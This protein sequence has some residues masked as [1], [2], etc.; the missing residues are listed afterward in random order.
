M[1]QSLALGQ[2]ITQIYTVTIADG[3]GG[4][5]TQDVTVTITGANDAP[6]IETTSD[7]FV[8]L[9]NPTQP[10]PTGST[11]SDIASGTISFADVDLIDRPVVTTLFTDY[12]YKAAD[13][14]PGLTLTTPQAFDVEATLSLTPSG[15]NTNNVQALRHHPA[16]L[17]PAALALVFLVGA[18][19]GEGLRQQAGQAAQTIGDLHEH[20]GGPV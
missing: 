19:V 20:G 10:N 14:T 2:T 1:L 3:H 17:V 9:T 6:T 8:E 16:R 5:V 7:A 4:A 11:T 12:I 18:H 13:G 15:G